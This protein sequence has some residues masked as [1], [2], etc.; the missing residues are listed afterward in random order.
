VKDQ[1][2]CSLNNQYS[3]KNSEDETCS[4]GRGTS[5]GDKWEMQRVKEI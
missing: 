2:E 5:E 4:G 1:G 3:L